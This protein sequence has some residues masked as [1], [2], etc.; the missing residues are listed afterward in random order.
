MAGQWNQNLPGLFPAETG[1][2]RAQQVGVYALHLLPLAPFLLGSR[3]F[4]RPDT[5]LPFLVPAEE[6]PKLS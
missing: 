6:Q 5:L 1:P 3:E 2:E 4:I